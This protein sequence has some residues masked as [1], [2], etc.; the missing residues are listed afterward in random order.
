MASRNSSTL[1]FVSL[2]NLLLLF[3]SKVLRHYRGQQEGMRTVP[4]EVWQ[5]FRTS[6][7]HSHWEMFGR[8]TSILCFPLGKM[9]PALDKHLARGRFHPGNPFNT[10]PT[11][12]PWGGLNHF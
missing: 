6:A 12:P 1:V 2:Q 3:H 10:L 5:R 7:F 4:P 8:N 11:E 9:K